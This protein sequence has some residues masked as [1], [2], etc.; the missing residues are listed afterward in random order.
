AAGFLVVGAAFLGTRVGDE[1]VSSLTLTPGLGLMQDLQR[2]SVGAAASTA[3]WA[4]PVELG[5]PVSNFREILRLP[6]GPADRPQQAVQ[7][8]YSNGSATIS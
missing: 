1:V 4:S 7:V 8:L 6:R 5:S 3:P 2:T